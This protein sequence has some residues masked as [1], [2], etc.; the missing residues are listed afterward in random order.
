M[1]IEVYVLAWNE[2]RLIN[3]FIDWYAF[4]DI[5]VLDNYSTD[6]TV[7][8]ARSRGCSVIKYG[9][10]QQD[11][12]AMKQIKEDCWKNSKADWVVVCDMDEFLYHPRLLSLLEYTSATVIQT[13]GYQMVS[14]E[15]MPAIDLK[16][17]SREPG[18]DK[19]ICF[20]PG[21]I[22]SMNWDH[23]CHHCNPIGE[24][25]TLQNTVKMLHYSMLGKDNM[26]QRWSQYRARMSQWDIDHGAGAHYLWPDSQI[27]QQF[28]KYKNTSEKVW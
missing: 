16:F 28:E 27:D 6:T 15:P 19:S 5:T 10:M 25:R 9:S 14:E 21:K 20:R 23:G 7:E 3:Q 1:K 17:G 4:A 22:T 12:Q 11:N 8:L 13:Q 2:E 18:L 26:K 24:I